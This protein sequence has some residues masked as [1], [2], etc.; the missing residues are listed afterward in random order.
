MNILFKGYFYT[1]SGYAEGNRALLRILHGCGYRVRIEPRDNEADKKLALTSEEKQY[2]S[3]F[4]HTELTSN[5]IFLFRG[6]GSALHT[7]PDFRI[8]IAHTTFETDRIPASWVSTLNQFDEVWV[9]CHFNMKTFE[10]SGV[11]APLRF[12]PYFFNDP[13]YLPQ[14]DKFPLPLSQTFKFLSVFDLIER[15]G[16]DVLLR[17]YLNEFSRSDDVALVIKVRDRDGV[18]KL[19]RMIEAHPKSKMERPPVYIMDQM[20]LTPELLSLYRACSAFVLPTRGEGWGRPFFEAMLMEM[21]TIGT[22]WSGQ[23]EYMNEENSYLIRVKKLIPVRLKDHPDPSKYEGHYWAEPSTKD[24][25]RKMR[26]VYE[27][28]DEAKACGRR[29]R[30]DLLKTYSLRKVAKHVAKEI[31][32]F[33]V[34]RSV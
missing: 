17:A 33:A 28:Q 26:F 25:Q 31:N 6:S 21:P 24:V 29:A 1:G 27:H 8:N 3:S 34:G 14:G 15:K 22:R 20:L 12:I 9:Q 18:E 23:L 30:Q 19:E 2:L 5:D 13:A 4:E 10:F 16:Y 32:K 11:K 7:R